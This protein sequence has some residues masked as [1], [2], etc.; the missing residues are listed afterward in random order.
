[1]DYTDY[2]GVDPDLSEHVL[3]IRRNR[4]ELNKAFTPGHAIHIGRVF[5]HAEDDR[6]V[7]AAVLTGVGDWFLSGADLRSVDLFAAGGQIPQVNVS[8][9]VFLPVL[10]FSKPLI[11][12]VNGGCAGGGLGFALACDMRI[13]S[14][15]VRIAASFLRIG[16]TANNTV[17]YLL[18]R[19]VGLAKALELMYIA[20]PIDA[21]EAERIGLVSYVVPPEELAHRTREL[22]LKFAGAPPFATQLSKRLAVDGLDRTYREHVLAQEYSSLDNRYIANHDIEERV[23]SFREKRPANFRGLLAKPKWDGF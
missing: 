3:T 8:E 19:I 2:E 1:L 15:S 4:P 17:A 18:P 21:A 14:S 23:A 16:L 7:R 12:A 10:E 9:N 6:D 11:A 5:Q 22:A 13:A 20:R